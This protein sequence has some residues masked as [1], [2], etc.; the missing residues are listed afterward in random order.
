MSKIK[1]FFCGHW[2][3]YYLNRDGTYRSVCGLCGK[4][5]LKHGQVS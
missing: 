5:L 2:P 3:N 4:E 1:Q